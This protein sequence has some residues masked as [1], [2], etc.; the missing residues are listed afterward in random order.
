MEQNAGIRQHPEQDFW[1]R[2]LEAVSR[3]QARYLWL[4]L[5]AG[6]FYAAL[7]AR[8]VNSHP[9]KVPV[10]DLELD[11]GTVLASGG[12]IMAFLV[13]VMMG[14]I[15]AWT[16]ALMHISGASSAKDAEKLDTHPNAI[17]L[18]VY[19]TKDSPA[20]LRKLLYFAYP[21]FLITALIESLMLGYSSLRTLSASGQA[22]LI[23]AQALTWIPATI[24][25]LIMWATRFKHLGAP[26]G[27][28]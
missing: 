25:V 26:S 18:A 16:N 7:H 6:V 21:L 4:L 28:V 13:L 10:V 3:A 20:L 5:I 23:A 1:I 27:A 14:A 19:T 2:R 8:G 24:L 12:P 15:R 17:D 22:L 9:V 11:A